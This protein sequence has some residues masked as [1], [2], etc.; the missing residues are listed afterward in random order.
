MN[1]KNWSK[2]TTNSWVR[3]I[4]TGTN[5]KKSTRAWVKLKTD[6]SK[7][8]LSRELSICVTKS[9]I[10]PKERKISNFKLMRWI[11]HSQ[12]L[13][14]VW[15]TGSKKTTLKSN[16]RKKKFQIWEKW[17]R[18]IKRTSKRFKTKFKAAARLPKM[19]TRKNTK[20]C[21]K[22]KKRSTSLPWSSKR[23]KLNTRP[24]SKTIKK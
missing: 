1:T 16:N 23:K 12:K 7:T 3:L 2:T 9:I 24:I 10:C 22:K 17:L 13:V 21:I 14:N 11:S 19:K 4:I 18:L 5:L 8:L 6:S 20:S 15:W